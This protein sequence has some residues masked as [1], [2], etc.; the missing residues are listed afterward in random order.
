[1][2][3]AVGEAVLVGLGLLEMVELTALPETEGVEEVESVGDTLRD[4]N[5]EREGGR[6]IVPVPEE[7]AVVEGQGEAER[8]GVLALDELPVRV[9]HDGEGTT[10]IVED[11]DKMGEAESVRIND[12]D[13]EMDGVRDDDLEEVGEEEGDIDSVG[14]LNPPISKVFLAVVTV[15]K[16]RDPGRTQSTV[17]EVGSAQATA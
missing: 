5:S 8:D 16:P 4:P 1:M 12:D 15:L 14:T 10:E 11:M 2:T 9:P 3:V 17:D 7:N 13:V 6:D